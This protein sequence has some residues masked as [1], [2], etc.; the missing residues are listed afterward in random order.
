MYIDKELF[1]AWMERIMDYFDKLD[2]KMENMSKKQ[3]MLDGQRLFD[4]QDLCQ[5]LNVSKR[6][7]Q[8]YRSLQQLP[9][10]TIYHKT[11]YKEHDVFAFIKNHFDEKDCESESNKNQNKPAQ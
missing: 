5:L 9:Y 10:K 8:R 2:K 7:L 11:Y 6:T 1:E 4:N 3:N